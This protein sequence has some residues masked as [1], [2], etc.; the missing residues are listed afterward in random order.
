L[1]W[2]DP[3]EIQMSLYPVSVEL[4]DHDGVKQQSPTHSPPGLQ[5][6][7]DRDKKQ[8]PFTL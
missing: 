2:Y 1:T 8:I 7:S 4:Y 3:K 5:T 6:W